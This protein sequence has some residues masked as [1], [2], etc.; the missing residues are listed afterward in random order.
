MADNDAT[1]ATTVV[2]QVS[3]CPVPPVDMASMVANSTPKTED[4]E[5]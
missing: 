2:A 5:G 3:F 4:S 1:A